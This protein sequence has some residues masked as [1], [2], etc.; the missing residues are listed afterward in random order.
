MNDVMTEEKIIKHSI[1][2]H[3][4]ALLTASSSASVI[5]ASVTSL[6][7]SLTAA[8]ASTASLT[9]ASLSRKNLTVLPPLSLYVHFPWCVRKCPY[10]DFNSHEWKKN[11]QGL[12]EAAYIKALRR[13]IELA[14]PLIWGRP[15]R[16]VFIG[17]GT[18]SLIS[19]EGLDQLLSDIRALLPLDVDAEITLE[20]NPGTVEAHK[21]KSFRDSGI[22][23]LSLGI[24]S[25]ND[26]ALHKL[27]RIHGGHEARQAIEIA[28]KY[29]ENFNLDVMFALPGQTMTAC[30]Q[31]V[32]QALS[33]AP[34][35][36]SLYQ[37]TLEPNT[38][39]HKFPPEL[40]DEDTAA[41]M[42]DWIHHRMHESA[43]VHY[44][45]SA[46]AKPDRQAAHNLNYWRFGDYLG[47][48]A[49]AHSKISFPQ[50]IIRQVRYRQPEEY[51]AHSLTDTPVQQ[52]HEIATH[53][54]PFEF[55]LNALR[56]VHGVDIASF[57]ERTG[58]P[59]T[60][61]QKILQKA[62]DKKM[63]KRDHLNMA[64]T[65]LGQRFLNDLQQLF[66][67]QESQTKEKK[68]ISLL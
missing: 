11:S 17:G 60:A 58:L 4:S 53:D 29:F 5:A 25:F 61:I 28:Q 16:T 2:K 12:P 41:D 51:M 48:G 54:L 8:S 39:F 47:I 13:D 65:K 52:S 40:P 22:N 50:K 14:L 18:P 10:C 23:R 20:A 55:M 38:Y 44:E 59:I 31:D 7:T 3:P 6:T 42:Q 24:Q 33:Y 35:H 63:L 68:V 36:L 21:F 19:S 49:G 30:Q 27:G 66:L 9:A 15:I 56:L 26:E 46:Y 67:W 34:P 57:T 64:P 43:Y 32:E 45:V 62:E 37:L 1:I